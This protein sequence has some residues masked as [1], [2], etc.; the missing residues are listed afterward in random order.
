MS[1][2]SSRTVARIAGRV[3]R[4]LI[5]LG[6]A[7]IV[8]F[9]AL[10]RTE[11]GRDG[12]RR[13]IETAF[14]ERFAGSLQIDTLRGTLLYDLYA[15]DVRLRDEK[16]RLVAT[17]DSVAAEPQ[18]QNLL[19]AELSADALTLVRP[20]LR[21]HR[22]TNGTWNVQR[23][24]QRTG[25]ST[26]GRALDFSFAEVGIRDGR[27]TTTR[28]G[29]APSLVADRWLF[30]YT[31]SEMDQI[32]ARATIEWGSQ[33]RHVALTPL[34]F[35]LPEQ[36]LALESARVDLTEEA[37]RWTLDTLSLQLGNTDVQ[38]Q[39]RVQSAPNDST[40]H[41]AE[42]Q[43]A[44]SRVDHD[45][46]RR[47]VPRLPL[48]NA[49]TIE[50]RMGGS[51][52]R[53][54]VNTLQLSHGAST[55]RLEGTVYGLPDSLDVDAQLRSSRVRPSD[56]RSVWPE[57]PLGDMAALGPV[58]VSAAVDGRVDWQNRSTPAFDLE[59]T[60]SARGSPGAVQGSLDVARPA[61]GALR[62]SG[63]LRT[64]SLDLAPLTGTPRLASRLT[65]RVELDG[66]GSDLSSA[67]GTFRASLDAGRV[68]PRRF[69]AAELRLSADAEQTEG[70]FTL[71]QADGGTLRARGTVQTGSAG[72]EYELE[73][74]LR[75]F[76]LDAVHPPL[77]PSQLN[78]DLL[79]AGRGEDWE[80][81]VGTLDLDVDRSTLRNGDTPL[82]PHQATLTLNAPSAA[83]P[84][85]QLASSVASGTIEGRP[86]RP[87]TRRAGRR[88]VGAGRQAIRREIAKAVRGATDST[89]RTAASSRL[90]SAGSPPIPEAPV[91]LEGNLT[92]HRMDLVRAWWPDAPDRGDGLSTSAQVTVGPDTLHAAGRLGV[93]RLDMGPRRIDSL[94]ASFQLSAP[95][96]P[97][98][99]SNAA[100][101][102]TARAD[103]LRL[104]GQSLVHP[105]V[106]FTLQ[107]RTGT[108]RARTR[109]IGRTGPY[110]FAADLT[111]QRG[112]HARLTTLSA[113]AG[114]YAWTTAQATRASVY[115]DAL[116]LDTL[117]LR[118]SH[119][120]SQ[121]D[122][123]IRVSGTLSS[124]PTD[125][126]TAEMRDVLLY[127]AGE[128]AALPRA[129]GGTLNGRIAF[130]GGWSRPQVES[131][132]RVR[133]LSFDRRLL[134][135]LE[136]RTRIPPN[137]P[138]LLVDAT[139]S[140][141]PSSLDRVDGPPLVPDGLRAVEENQLSLSG[142][143]RL[144]GQSA[145]ASS[146]SDALD[147]TAEIERADLFFFKYIFD[148]NLAM[149]RGYTA[150]TIDVGGRFR[151]PVF[152]ADLAIENARF[153]LPQ[154]GL[155][156]SASGP[157]AVDRRGI[158]LQGLTVTDDEGSATLD[159]SV[160]F[161][162][163]RY[164]S[165]DLSAELD[166]LTII[167]VNQAGSLAFYGQIRAS[168][169][170]SLTG[171]L[172]D[173]TL[174]S[175]GARTTPD[176]ELYIPV[177]EEGVE[178][179][180]G[181]IV[182]ADSTGQIPDLRDLTRRDNIF[183]DR[184]AGEPSFLEGLEI[185][186]NVLAPE[187]S[188]VHLVFD[189]V[190]GDVVTAV[191]SGR[192]QLQRQ[193][194]GFFVYGNFNVSGG[195]YLFTAGEVFV[196]RFTINGG[197]I[198]WDGPPTNAQLDLEAEYRTRASRAGLPGFSGDEGRIPVRVLL[199][200]GGRVETPRVD[201]SLA[202][203]RDERSNLVGSR[204]LDAILNQAD[205]TTE[206]ATSVLLTNTFL[207][208]TESFTQTQT[209]GPGG[210]AGGDLATA[211]NRLA[212]N[213]VSQLVASQLNRYL[214]AALPN[215]DLNFGL[216][217]ENT[218]DLDLIYGVALRLLNERLIIRGE[219]VY[220][221]D[222]PRNAQAD[223]PQGEFVVEVRLSSR[224]SVEAFYRRTGDELTYGQT[225]T[226]STGAGVSY[227]T[228]FPTWRLLLGRVFGWLIPGL[229]PPEPPEPGD[230]QA[231]PAD[232]VARTD[233]GDTSGSDDDPEQ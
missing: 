144:P 202:Q 198:T 66:R 86:F 177:S 60:L 57:A 131:D 102:L 3:V 191:G 99:L 230:E 95:M 111:L 193:E 160:L 64:D 170:A 151:R 158:H 136:V 154:F 53:L 68:G 119:P 188:T 150:G 208:T 184:P 233:D 197:T 59:G 164:F 45:Q 65:G 40:R 162:D 167:D 81:L 138:D 178:D 19:T 196:R 128:L 228:E 89:G 220:T 215:V 71:R 210:A 161:N 135:D 74:A 173:A 130:T 132:L 22:R 94:R 222:D 194:G 38:A 52:D 110:E 115:A 227:Q 31:Q 62:Y 93:P 134:G 153:T 221:S 186:V 16:G 125:S 25:S 79:L 48:R 49:L 87:A 13:Q 84:R 139:L 209:A 192:V 11:V 204:T 17:I 10:T 63:R 155:E 27:V 47:L 159:G 201:L 58:D 6:L 114:Q 37:D 185:D 200:I 148:E 4:G 98:L 46:L 142:R 127:P 33:R 41:V 80:S 224:V 5:Y 101:E 176:S 72:P 147:L 106:G 205:R 113:D 189:P 180:T 175:D 96:R 97:D 172:Q 156:Y 43:F 1:D 146:A 50:G 26:G 145:P 75:T 2:D 39:G 109:E 112:L 120:A 35:R 182:F 168:G 121:T 124:A 212:F 174:R 169:P 225:L 157:L 171:P 90:P 232:P 91:R 181:F 123:H 70:R 218:E 108:V 9:F 67:L 8:L 122:Q 55:A 100:A 76:D 137:T 29:D 229:R 105:R 107:E 20:H 211:G 15:T 213:S 183:S 187:E 219:G 103:T 56:L 18:W 88:W 141:G 69:A 14:N 7:G 23:A 21:L 195:T 118:S 163:Y 129:L 30:D 190:V 51:I 152:D 165:F 24:L 92:I 214:G 104:N 117:D 36:D 199:D 116:V 207:L 166:E 42:L 73:A 77:P 206:Y 28:T 82:P 12:V 78:A 149:A 223:G 44:E 85:V 83:A 140:P 216:Q 133:R 61:D 226:S 32:E 179:G 231:P 217:G 143:V 126:L 203:V 34:Q 54:V